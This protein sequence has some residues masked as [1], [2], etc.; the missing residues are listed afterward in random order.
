MA[1]ASASPKRGWIAALALCAT[2][3]AGVV[4]AALAIDATAQS[5]ARAAPT[6]CP[7]AI[8]CH[9]LKRMATP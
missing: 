1:S 6:A 9:A 5:T 8:A 2:L 4:A 7:D 3:L